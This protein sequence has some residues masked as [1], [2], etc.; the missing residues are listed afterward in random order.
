[1]NLKQLNQFVVIAQ[2]LN[3]RVAAARL[4]MAQ[5]PLSVSIRQLEEEIG[6]RLFDR[7]AAGV[8]LTPVGKTV[9]EHAR[10]SLFHAEE[11]RHAAQLAAGGQVG[12]LRISFVASSTLRLL[13]RTIA[14]F[15]QH[16]PKVDLRLSEAG[17]VAIVE[18]LR[19]GLIDVGLVRSPAPNHPGV[20]VTIVEEDHYIAALPAHHALA[21]R[22][23]LRLSDLKD[24]PFILP[25]PQDGSASHM[26]MMHACW[27]AGFVP[28]I[29]QEASQAQ[30]ILA[31]VECGLGVAMVP[32][33]WADMAPRNIAYRELW[34]LPKARIGLAFACRRDERDAVLLRAFR[35]SIE[36]GA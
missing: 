4:H 26:S 31:L 19:D 29:V 7:S 21:G 3:F 27:Q 36:A 6:Q 25:S 20:S 11:F 24:E 34:G 5:P 13:P 2:T 14:H 22:K 1:M 15:R 33:L 10:R 18:A 28:N 35:A 9:L 17:T 23:R 12:S 32:K 16:H 8:R 30:T